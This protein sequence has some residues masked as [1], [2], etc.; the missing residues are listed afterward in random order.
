M[1]NPKKTRD[2][3]RLKGAA[4]SV[5]LMNPICELQVSR[6]LFC[7]ARIKA[8]RT[9]STMFAVVKGQVRFPQE[10]VQRKTM[11][12]RNRYPDA[13]ADR[14]HVP[15]DLERLLHCRDQT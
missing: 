9:A 3:S 10:L 5:F 1:S 7:L 11:V 15:A 14:Y 13:G 8:K 12:G 2:R 6:T 4:P